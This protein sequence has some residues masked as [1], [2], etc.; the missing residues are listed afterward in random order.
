MEDYSKSRL[1]RRIKITDKK[2]RKRVQYKESQHQALL[3]TFPGIALIHA[4]IGN[5]ADICLAQGVLICQ[6]AN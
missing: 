3:S 2:A 5:K 1:K 6:S 4:V